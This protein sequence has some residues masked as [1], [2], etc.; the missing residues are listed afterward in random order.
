MRKRHAI[1]PSTTRRKISLPF[2]YER[3]RLA[4]TFSRNS[5]SQYGE[6]NQAKSV[7][8]ESES[9]VD[10]SARKHE[11]WVSRMP[12]ELWSQTPGKA[13][14]RYSTPTNLPTVKTAWHA[15][16]MLEA[17]AFEMGG[18]IPGCSVI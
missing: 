16:N 14:L 4:L 15:L 10:I 18:E 9:G 12:S 17:V 7:H 8:K 13:Y 2:P 11:R 3:V 6:Q 5:R 1:P